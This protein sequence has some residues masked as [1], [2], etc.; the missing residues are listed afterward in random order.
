MIRRAEHKDLEILSELA[1][2]LWSGHTREEL[3][4]ELEEIMNCQSAFYLAFEDGNAAGFAQCQLRGDYVEGTSSSPV[5]YLEGIFVKP[6]YRRKGIGRELIRCC[7]K[8]AAENCC[9][10]FA[11]DCET[12]NKESFAFHMGAGFN[13]ANRIICFVKS[14]Q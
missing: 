12:D 6:Q 9:T 14:I 11:S 8:W 1:G 3:L 5:G 7:E 4:S 10:E 13:E 2:M